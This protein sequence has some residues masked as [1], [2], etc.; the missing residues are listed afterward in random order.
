MFYA[1]WDSDSIRLVDIFETVARTFVDNDIYMAAVNCWD[2]KGHCS[3][4]FS[5]GTD[6]VNI[7][8]KVLHNTEVS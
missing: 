8:N 7:M 1:P 2:P 6:R 3:K 4:E 5:G